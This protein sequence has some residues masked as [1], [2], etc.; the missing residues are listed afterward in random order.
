MGYHDCQPLAEVRLCDRNAIVA[1]THARLEVSPEVG[2]DCS[3]LR[4]DT[5]Q[6]LVLALKLR[7]LF[8]QRARSKEPVSAVAF[9]LCRLYGR[10]KFSQQPMPDR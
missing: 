1:R 5:P 9:L 2:D 10:R 4:V 3:F 6:H 8:A 7:V